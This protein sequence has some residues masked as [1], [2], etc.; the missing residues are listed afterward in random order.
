MRFLDLSHFDF[1]LPS[2]PR[3]ATLIKPLTVN[4]QLATCSLAFVSI[5]SSDPRL[6]I[7]ATIGQVAMGK[8]CSGN[9]VSA[10]ISRSRSRPDD[11]D[12]AS[13]RRRGDPLVAPPAVSVTC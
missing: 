9:N 13:R 3:F 4:R 1:S 7:P 2:H 12:D 5:V 10:I 8:L 11:N 6:V